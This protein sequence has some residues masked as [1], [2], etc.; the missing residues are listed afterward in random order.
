MASASSKKKFRPSTTVLSANNTDD[1]DTDYL[2]EDESMIDN[3]QK[4]VEPFPSTLR[5]TFRLSSTPNA[6]AGAKNTENEDEHSEGNNQK[7]DDVIHCKTLS[8]IQQLTSK[9]NKE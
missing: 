4:D 2:S 8:G 7:N 5:R 6:T 9:D 1:F 3:S